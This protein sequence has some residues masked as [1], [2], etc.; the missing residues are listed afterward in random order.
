MRKQRVWIASG[1]DSKGKLTRL[2]EVI[3]LKGL[4][5]AIEQTV[6]SKLRVAV[7]EKIMKAEKSRA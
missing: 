4:K 5:R 6:K 7:E 1:F 2:E 3:S